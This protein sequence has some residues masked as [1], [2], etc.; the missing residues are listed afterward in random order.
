MT[1]GRGAGRSG[2]EQIDV[3]RLA[4]VSQKTVSRVVNNAPHVR[5]D[6]RAKVFAAI[7]ELGYRPNVAA[8]AL[9]RNRTH[10]IGM[11]AAEIT[12]HGPGRRVFTIEQAARRH[13]YG[14]VL[15]SLPDLAPQTVAAALSDLLDRGA[16]GLVIEVPSHLL[17]LD[18]SRLGDMPVV[19]T[20]DRISGLDRQ[21]VVDAD[22]IGAARRATQHLLELGHET[23]WH[24]AGPRGW[25]AA[26]KRLQGWRSGLRAA[27]R[28][29]PRAL[30]G[31]WSARS[32]YLQ[33]RKLAVRDD[34]TAIFAANDHMTMGVL[35][36]LT[37][38]GRRVPGDVSVIGYDDVPEAEFQIIPLTTVASDAA[39]I[40]ERMLAELVDMIEG[41]RP[42]AEHIDLATS[43]IIRSSSGPPPI[44]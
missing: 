12:M 17:P 37:E 32:G 5:P 10:I 43:L 36:A 27:G 42:S 24:L 29:V 35:R 2:P 9:A 7:E 6:V 20:G 41:A 4:G 8:Q 39:G 23:V 1:T 26:E 16:E 34:V 21:I 28:R 33:G 25:D 11:L 40:A 14:L 13:G 30:S 18:S 15:A 31:D 19:K 22:Q 3:A 44:T 38:S